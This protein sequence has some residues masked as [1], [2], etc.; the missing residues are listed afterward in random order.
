[1]TASVTIFNISSPT[2]EININVKHFSVPNGG[3]DVAP[4]IGAGFLVTQ[5]QTAT[6]TISPTNPSN[7]SVTV[8]VVNSGVDVIT[9][10]GSTVIVGGD[11][12]VI[13]TTDSTVVVS[14]SQ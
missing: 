5:Y 4:M 13:L 3:F 2:D 7:S 9:V 6:V 10:N 1:M 14:I 12:D 11:V 8:K